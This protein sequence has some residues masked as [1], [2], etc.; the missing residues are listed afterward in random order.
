[1]ARIVTTA[2]D[3]ALA[4]SIWNA[5]VPI[6][7]ASCSEP[8]DLWTPDRV[9]AE[10]KVGQ[11]YISDDNQSLFVVRPAVLEAP[12]GSKPLAAPHPLERIWASQ[13][14]LWAPTT[15]TVRELFRFWFQTRIAAKQEE[16]AFGWIYR[17]VAVPLRTWLDGGPFQQADYVNQFGALR[18]YS[19]H[20]AKTVGKL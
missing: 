8:V 9:A 14:A 15:T 1:M 3:D 13:L 4:A 20:M 10:R 18:L 5:Q 19:A 11:V 6:T 16:Y 12:P 17:T 7:A 2:V